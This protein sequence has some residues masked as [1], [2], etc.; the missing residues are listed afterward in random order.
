MYVSRV[1]NTNYPDFEERHL[2]NYYTLYVGKNTQGDIFVASE[3]VAQE[4][5]QYS[6]LPNNSVCVIDIAKR[7]HV[8]R[9]LL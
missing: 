5:T 3:K 4:D 8:V 6:L 2:E 9:A 7:T 1:M